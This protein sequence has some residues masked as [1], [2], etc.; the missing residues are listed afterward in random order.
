MSPAKRTWLAWLMQ[1]PGPV[2]PLVGTANPEHIAEAAEALGIITRLVQPAEVE[3]CRG[4]VLV[5]PTEHP[6]VREPAHELAAEGYEVEALSLTLS[7]HQYTPI[8]SGGVIERIDAHDMLSHT[9]QR[10]RTRIMNIPFLCGECHH[11]GTPV[12]RTHDIPQDRILENYSMSIH[13][14]GLYRQGLTVTAV[15]TSSGPTPAS[16]RQ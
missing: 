10:S 1:Q 13:G 8:F 9:D 7:R 2:I 16:S 15:C 5:G 4:H 11:E 6:S 3:A 14:E 12:S